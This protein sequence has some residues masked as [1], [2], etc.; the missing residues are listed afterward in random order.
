MPKQA[1]KKTPLLRYLIK[2]S[3]S[4]LSIYCENIIKNKK[5]KQTK[6]T[7]KATEKAFPSEKFNNIEITPIN[8]K[9][10]DSKYI[11]KRSKERLYCCLINVHKAIKAKKIYPQVRGMSLSLIPPLGKTKLNKNKIQKQNN[12]SLRVEKAYFFNVN[13]MYFVVAIVF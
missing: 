4:I 5:G 6:E 10:T 2:M 3:L 11:D 9:G 12:T 1:T 13:D 8:W 7:K